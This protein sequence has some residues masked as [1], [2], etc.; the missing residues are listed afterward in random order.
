LIELFV[1]ML[2]KKD[3]FS[4]ITL[5]RKSTLG[6]VALLLSLTI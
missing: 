6:L 1:I 2:T 3:L 5:T 4:L